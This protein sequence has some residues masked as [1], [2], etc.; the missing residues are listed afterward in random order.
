MNKKEKYFKRTLLGL[1]LAIWLLPF[2]QDHCPFVEFKKLEGWVTYS[3]NDSLSWDKWFDGSFTSKKEDYIKEQFGLRNFFLRARNQ[4]FYSLFKVPTASGVVIGKDNMLYEEKYIE[5]YMGR[6][7]IGEKAM[8]ERMQKLKFVSDTLKKLNVD[9]IVCFA[10]GKPTYYPEYIPDKYFKNCDTVN[11]NYKWAAKIAK[12]DGL[13]AIDYNYLFKSLKNKTRFPLYPKTGVHWSVYG[14]EYAFDTLTKY[15]EKLK[16]RELRHYK[17]GKVIWGDSMREQDEDIGQA[18]NTL[19]EIEHYTMPYPILEYVDTA[20]KYQPRVITISDSYWINMHQMW[21][22]GNIFRN[23]EFWY[24]YNDNWGY[25]G[26]KDPSGY[27]LKE[28][29][30]NSDVIV[31]MATEPHVLEIGWGFV[32]DA[33]ELY[34]TGNSTN[35]SA[36]NEFIRYKRWMRTEPKLMFDLKARAKKQ[37]SLLEDVMDVEA[38][39]R[40]DSTHAVVAIKE[41]KKPKVLTKEELKMEEILV[42]NIKGNPEWMQE[43]TKKATVENKPIETVVAA[44]IKSIINDKGVF[45]LI[46]PNGKY[47][48]ADGAQNYKVLAN[49]DGGGLWETFTFLHL[50]DNFFVISS[51]AYKFFS[52]EMHDK[53]KVIANRDLFYS[54]ERFTVVKVDNDFVAIKANANGKYLSL[55]E[56]TGE[57]AATSDIIGKNE[58]FKLIK[59]K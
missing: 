21:L 11:T 20:G 34:K 23:Y 13:N 39:H 42:A 28:K 35:R 22:P 47:L 37:N 17:Y 54:W 7:F 18:L 10:P 31:L 40:I 9:L 44:E 30:Q 4:V 59:V 6:D 3:P 51:W 15:I 16:G 1:V 32:E 29:I 49:R 45:Q 25:N 56:K 12:E 33:Y 57:I 50:K 24:F 48:C 55:E 2:Y 5:S 38:R 43:L 46:A 53:A 36:S 19:F 52:V 8:R 27:N 26:P 14:A 58:K 41:A